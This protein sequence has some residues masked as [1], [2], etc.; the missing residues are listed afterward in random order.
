M[1]EPGLR[2]LREMARNGTRVVWRVPDLSHWN[3]PETPKPWI[4]GACPKA[5]PSAASLAFVPT[6]QLW[7]RD[8]ILE[9]TTETEIDVMD[10]TMLS[11][12]RP[13]AHPSAH[14]NKVRFVRPSLLRWRA[15][16]HQQE[17][18][19]CSHHALPDQSELMR[20]MRKL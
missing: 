16:T 13:D 5:H 2:V 4:H 12:S 19:G 6:H 11:G 20:E 8:I 14:M 18:P 9:M 3:N 15:F 1:L 10:V 7:L 17:P